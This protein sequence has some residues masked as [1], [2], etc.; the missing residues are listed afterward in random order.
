[1]SNNLL[2]AWNIL[3]TIM[4]AFLFLNMGHEERSTYDTAQDTVIC[5]YVT[6]LQIQTGVDR[7]TLPDCQGDV[8][9]IFHSLNN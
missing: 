3:L 5:G 4:F 6:D 7:T 9:K 8:E 2:M 1:M